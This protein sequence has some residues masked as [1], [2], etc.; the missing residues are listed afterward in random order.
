MRRRG[1]TL[2][3]LLVVVGIIA[4]LIALLLPMLVKAREAARDIVCKSNLR[5]IGV[6][7][8]IYM[9]ENRLLLHSGVDPSDAAAYKFFSE[10]SKTSW[11]EKV[12]QL[13]RIPST[14]RSGT[15]LHCPVAE[16][17]LGPYYKAGGGEYA[18]VPLLYSLNRYLGVNKKGA[19]TGS[20]G[21]PARPRVGL[22]GNQMAWVTDTA[23]DIVGGRMNPQDNFWPD[24]KPIAYTEDKAPWPYVWRQYRGHGGRDFANYLIGDGH[25]ESVPY[26]FAYANARDAADGSSTWWTGKY[27]E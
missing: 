18:D 25:V 21:L 14:A 12:R 7:G 15:I 6:I 10:I 4:V 1:F 16:A 11:H 22:L 19:Y 3:E 8:F 24:K 9:N 17:K 23:G 20:G 13:A 5:Q 2:V 26:G 27:Q